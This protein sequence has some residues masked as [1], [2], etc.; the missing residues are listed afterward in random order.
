MYSVISGKDFNINA[1]KNGIKYYKILNETHTHFGFKYNNGL[2]IDTIPFNPTGKCQLGGLYFCEKRHLLLHLNHGTFISEVTI[3]DSAL[4][5]IEEYKFKA[6]KICLLNI[7]PL[8]ES[9]VFY[10][11]A[12]KHNGYA[13]L[14]VKEQTE[15]I[16]KLAVKQDGRAL[17]YV[18]EQTEEICKLAVEQNG[19]ALYFVENQTEEICKLAVKQ[20]GRALRDVEKQ[21]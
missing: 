16:C 20:D 4:V 19:S 8:N 17:Y 12:M 2:N 10:E 5:Y 21:T 6:D 18:K 7:H 9:E 14:H 13:L 3:P 11:L 15:E 1:T